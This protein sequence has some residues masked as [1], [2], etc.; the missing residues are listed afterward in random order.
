LANVAEVENLVLGGGEAGKYVAWELS[1]A[2]RPV[3]VVERAL[4]GGSCPNV[5]CLPSKNVIASARAAFLMRR[6]LSYGVYAGKVEIDMAGVRAHKRAMVAG[7][8]AIHEQ[9]FEAPGIDFVLGQGRFIGPHALEIELAGGDLRRVTAA[10]VFLDLGTRAAIP[11]VAGLAAAA[12]LTHIEALELD[13]VPERLVVL[14]GGPV[15]CEF[16]QAF[17]RLGARVTILERGS[18]LLPRED[19]DLA[20]EVRTLFS[21]EGIDVVLDAETL[22]VEGRSGAR[23]ELRVRTPAGE[24]RIE[25]TDLLVAAGRVPNTDGIGL[26]MAGVDVDARGYVKVDELLRTSMPEVWAMGECA[27]SPQFT[28]VAL[29]D[30]RIVRAQL[31]PASW[32]ARSTTDRLIP[33]CT[34]LDPELGRVGLSATEAQRHGREVRVVT[35]PMS[36]VLRARAMVETRG[37]MKTLLDTRSDRI[38]GFAMLGPNAGEVIA[39]VQMAMLAGLPYTA[40]RDALFTHP[41]MA[42][43]LNVLFANVPESMEGRRREIR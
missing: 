2:G 6:G 41:T 14:G 23:L 36:A 35:L 29:D 10:R 21:D 16:G 37:L 15:G 40:L 24:R 26:E 31:D 11:P 8:V 28:H 22:N 39:V 42:E 25:A 12:P 4:I 20:E 7:M 33:H 19:A 5:A 27:G 32:P 13:R 17:R 18:Q 1:K 43:G 38:L 9:K 34:F 3:T 30:F